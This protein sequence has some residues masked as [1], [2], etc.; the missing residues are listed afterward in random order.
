MREAPIPAE[1]WLKM[2]EP[3]L[4]VNPESITPGRSKVTL[5][6]T[7]NTRL[8]YIRYR[9]SGC[10]VAMTGR[11]ESIRQALHLVSMSRKRRPPL[12]SL[13]ITIAPANNR[14][15]SAT[16]VVRN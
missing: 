4:K 16:G 11:G 3:N 15:D 12:A 8:R 9:Q 7:Q 2:S 14:R 6:A 13:E 1:K 5:P 10:A